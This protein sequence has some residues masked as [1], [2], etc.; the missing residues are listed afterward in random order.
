MRQRART[1]GEAIRLFERSTERA[2]AK[3][4]DLKLF[5]AKLGKQG[6][7]HRHPLV[8]HLVDV[9][10]VA[11]G[12]WDSVLRFAL[13]TRVARSLSLSIDDAGRWLAF[14]AGSH[15][16]G[17]ASPAFQEK[18][19]SGEARRCLEA[20]GFRFHGTYD[21]PHGTVSTAV[22]ARVLPERHAWPAVEGPLAKRVATAVGGHHGVFPQTRQWF[23][24]SDNVLGD[25]TWTN[26]RIAILELLIRVLGVDCL[27]GPHVASDTEHWFFMFLAGLTSVSDWIGS[28]K[29]EF[30]HAGGDVD[31]A[32][33]F[34]Q[35]P[36]SAGRALEHLGWTGWRPDDE[37]TKSFAEMFAFAP[38]PLQIQSVE[39]AE[40]LTGPSLILV[41]APTGEGKTEAALFLSDR[42]IHTLGQQGLYFALPTQAT[43]N[44]MF[45]RVTKFLGERYP[46][47][48]VNAH[49]L[50]GHALLSDT[51]ER[52]RL[53]AVCDEG[54]DGA[55]VAETWFTRSQK[56]AL[57]APFG[58]GTIDQVLLAVLQTRHVFVRLFGL[59]GKTVVLDEVHAYDAYMSALLER[60]LAWLS[61]LGCSVILLSAT[62]PSAKRRSLLEAYSGR[63]LTLDGVPYPRMTVCNDTGARVVPVPPLNDRRTSIE[64]TWKKLE[65]LPLE[66]AA[67]LRYGGCAAVILNTV[68]LAQETYRRL[69]VALV[70]EGVEVELFHARFLFGRRQEIEERVLRRYG[71]PE[72]NP[73]R[74]QKAVLVAT[75]VIEQSLD[76]DFDLMVTE[77][78]P[79]DLI[80]QRVGRLHRHDRPARPIGKPPLLWIFEP[81][82]QDGVPDFGKTERVYARHVLLRSYL[83]LRDKATIRLP[84][85]TESLVEAVY[86][87]TAAP[88]ETRAWGEALEESWR[89]LV[90]E[91]REG[92][93][94]AERVVIKPPRYD[95]DILE[96]FCQELEEE[97]PDVHKSL[98]ALTRLTEP[99]VQV[100]C[101]Y[102]IGD[103]LFYD[104]A[105]KEPATDLS[106]PSLSNVKR[107]L[108][109]SIAVTHPGAVKHLFQ[110]SAYES[111][112]KHSLLCHHRLCE[113]DASGHVSLGDYELCVDGE[114]GM[115]VRSARD[116]GG[117]QP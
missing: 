2:G 6:Y 84:E 68:G 69:K 106:R 116:A 91:L 77:T 64:L 13:K 90:E 42:C 20:Y 26:A 108:R 33:Y 76:L 95:D 63:P 87:D 49:L 4:M 109:S 55:V 88:P 58:V 112:L 78:A 18:E 40:S 28:N 38:R 92:R 52:V 16:I 97:N 44:Q 24:L 35:A 30:P 14:W 21:V 47:Q 59:A 61:A 22:L 73:D 57:L 94:A 117:D 102:R 12:L 103:G 23:D 3:T 66:L 93:S 11:L 83:A 81:P 98:R 72:V 99:S 65:S 39:E 10:Y 70:A 29:I 104:A 7:E 9:A 15:D 19:R 85:D 86:A 113:L 45:D 67:A 74:P 107:L 31:L 79:V 101:L 60:L 114:L 105:A 82:T 8:C 56:Q 53:A 89:S 62:L 100:V 48:K 27:P 25:D 1:D 46:L 41:D 51:Y 115:I 50:H 34:Q 80:L 17:K 54:R 71:K 111:W 43:S 36:L 96:D 110:V 5:W 37:R 32:D 75:Q